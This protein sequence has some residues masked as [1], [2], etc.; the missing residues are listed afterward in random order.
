M[1][2]YA[3]I[4]ESEPAYPLPVA[5]ARD[6]KRVRDRF[7]P[8]LRRVVGHIPF[9]EDLAAA[10]F[11]AVDARTPARVRAVLLGALAYFV[12]PADLIPDWLAGLGFTDDASVLTL[13]MGIVSGHVRER[14]R[15]RARAA[16]FRPEP[17]PDED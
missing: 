9:A 13:A 17:K 7:W 12:L 3:S 15:D 8:K 5:V 2:S 6:E 16:L 14:H 1:R 4:P 11:C 10:Y